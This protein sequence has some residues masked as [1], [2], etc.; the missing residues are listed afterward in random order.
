MKPRDVLILGAG[1]A[2]LSAAFHLRDLDL[3]VIE[4]ADHVGGRTKSVRLP[5]EP[6][7]NYGAQYITEDRPHVVEIAD[8]VG[9]E[10][11]AFTGFEDYGKQLLPSDP[12]E[13]GEA[14]AAIERIKA[15]QNNPRP[16]TLP[17]LDDQ[18]FADWLGPM[19]T[20]A[21]AC[22]ETACELMNSAST[23]ELSL[24]GGLWIWGEQRSTP[25]STEKIPRHAR[26][27]LIVAGGT[28]ALAEA[29]ARAVGS[30]V[31][32]RTVVRRVTGNSEGYAVEAEDETGVRVLRARRVICTFPAPIAMDIIAD[33]PGWKRA[34]LRAV[35][36][37]R[38]ISTPIVV[39]SCE[40]PPTRFRLVAS[41][42]LVRYN[43]DTFMGRTPGDFDEAGGCFHSFMSNAAAR[44]VWD[45]PDD[46]ITSGAVRALLARFPEYRD[47]I[48]RVGI[49]RW[50]YGVPQYRRGLMKHFPALAEPVGGIHFCGDYTSQCN[51]EG[52]VRSGERAAAEVRAAMGSAA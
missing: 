27:E 46:S 38:M 45:D 39:T 11:L 50:P 34:A 9:V 8:A 36:Y 47:R 15:E 26:G 10:L 21:A 18:S 2:G 13:R 31:S 42:P 23:V 51:M 17:E 29:V 37:G 48:V 32:L 6:W 49:Q 40:M 24:Y 4:A 44:Q 12:A 35:R 30:R 43:I 52:A 7:N 3:E 1:L 22:F 25:W 33:L 41:R 16:A 28:Q 20:G 19:S 14:E 5:N